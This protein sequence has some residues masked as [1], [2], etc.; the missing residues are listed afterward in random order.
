MWSCVD[1]LLL[2]WWGGG[3]VFMRF[4]DAML[5]V[6][7][8]VMSKIVSVRFVCWCF[9]VLSCWRLCWWLCKWCCDDVLMWWW[10]VYDCV[11]VLMI[12]LMTVLMNVLIWSV[13]VLLCCWVDVLMTICWWVKAL[14]YWCVDEF[15]RWPTAN[16]LCSHSKCC[17]VNVLMC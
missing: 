17:F 5:C 9:D 10:C 1:G 12:V 3:A 2:F 4:C 13:G 6:D 8:D 16:E 14:I 11:R 15:T 7:V